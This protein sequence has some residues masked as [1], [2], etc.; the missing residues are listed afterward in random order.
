M[1]G[2]FGLGNVRGLRH[3]GNNRSRFRIASKGKNVSASHV[4]KKGPGRP[5]KP[6]ITRETAIQ[7]AIDVLDADGLSHLT[8]QAVARRLGVQSPSLYYH[9]RNREELLQLVARELLLRVGRAE[10]PDSSWEERAIDL[11]VATRRVI[12]RHANAAPLML[13]FFPRNI[14]LGAYERSLSTC[15]YAPEHRIA[16]LDAMEKL[17]Y[18]ASL[19][20]AAAS[21]HDGAAMPDFDQGRYP[22]LA[23]AIAQAP[24][25]GEQL[26]VET[27]RALLDGF[28]ARY[29]KADAER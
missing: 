27:L 11:A 18:G 20:D 22:L 23:E 29:R 26:F 13:R 1:P 2:G 5:S 17:T 12:M 14:M 10:R 4:R 21:T 3:G 15:P 7:T 6:L 28:R 19:F 9:F 16:I 24:V 8:V 25:A